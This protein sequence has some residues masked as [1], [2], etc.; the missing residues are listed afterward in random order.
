MATTADFRNGFTLKH[1]NDLWTIVEF[2]HVKPGK[3]PAFVRTKLKSLTSG[4][5]VENTFSAG[6]RVE[7]VRV[8]R[9]PFQFLYKD[10]MG[11]HFMNNETYEQIQIDEKVIDAPQFL[12]DGMEVTVAINAE[13][14]VP[15][16]CELPQHVVLEVTYT[17]P[18]LK[19]DTAT[20]TLKPG[21]VSSGAEVRIPL[22]INQ[23]DRIKIDTTTGAYVE[24]AKD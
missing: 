15:L 6:H 11:Y 16:T 1:N 22:F 17:E 10:D 4:K 14:E 23:G 5:V 24:R 20:N 12:I 19:G 2:Q 18:G 8:E 13:T 7:E 9:R 21:K 3:G